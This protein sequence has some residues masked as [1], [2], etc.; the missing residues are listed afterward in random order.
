MTNVVYVHSIHP[1]ESNPK[2]LGHILKKMGYLVR[3]GRYKNTTRSRYFEQLIRRFNAY[4]IDAHEGS[5]ACPTVLELIVPNGIFFD[6]IKD[7]LFS[8]KSFYRIE[9]MDEKVS[10]RV[11][12]GREYIL[13]NGRY[14]KTKR[15]WTGA[16]RQY[17]RQMKLGP[18]YL[19]VEMHTN[20]RD[21]KKS[22]TVKRMINFLD[23]LSDLNS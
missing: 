1:N 7:E 3:D 14:E 17:S 11:I 20:E 22:K 10:E 15:Y 21:I 5:H 12:H 6:R 18:R 23:L 16:P 8:L 13:H 9:V 19:L 4:A 2:E